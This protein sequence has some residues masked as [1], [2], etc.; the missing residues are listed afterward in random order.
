MPLSFPINSLGP[1][2]QS[3]EITNVLHAAASIITKPGSSQSE[4][5]I[6]PK[7]FLK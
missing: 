5:E 2:E 3:L 4:L 1:L 6:N 7:D